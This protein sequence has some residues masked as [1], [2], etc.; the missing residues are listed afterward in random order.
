ME[1][2]AALPSPETMVVALPGR[3]YL[4]GRVFAVMQTLRRL[5]E[6]AARSPAAP[7][8]PVLRDLLPRSSRR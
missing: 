6:E 2:H 1:K 3:L 4:V 7:S 5:T 8:P